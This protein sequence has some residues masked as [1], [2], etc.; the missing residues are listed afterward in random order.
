MAR[1][2][3]TAPETELG[4]RYSRQWHWGRAD[5]IGIILVYANTMTLP[6]KEQHQN[7]NIRGRLPLD[8]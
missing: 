4:Q 3:F 7:R 5:G 1:E 8:R 6:V 2:L